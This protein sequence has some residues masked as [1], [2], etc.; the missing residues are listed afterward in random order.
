MTGQYTLISSNKEAIVALLYFLVGGA[1]GKG[2]YNPNPHKLAAK[3]KKSI[4]SFFS[5]SKHLQIIE[6]S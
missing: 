1:G 6:N 5:V 4:Y 2:E 3:E